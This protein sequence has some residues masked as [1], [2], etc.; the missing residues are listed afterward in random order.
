MGNPLFHWEIMVDDSEA[1]IEF[2][3]RVFDWEFDVEHFPR[4]PLIKTG[5]NPGG[6]IFPKPKSAPN[7]KSQV[8]VY[9]HVDDIEDTLARVKDHGGTV[10]APKMAIPG[11]GYYAMF[12]DPEGVSV[13]ILSMA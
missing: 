10:I 9:F 12:T 1:A 6:A 4:Y 2:Y 11:I 3:S 8:N 13:G 7:A 5:D